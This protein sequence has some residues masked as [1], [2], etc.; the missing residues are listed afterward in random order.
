MDF[1]LAAV[2]IMTGLGV[3]FAA[4]LATADHFLRVEEDPKL[5][6]VESLLPG[7]NCGAC[8]EPGCR[9]LAG[10]LVEGTAEPAACTVSSHE[11]L[12]KIAAVL[13]V[14]VGVRE[15]VVARL[16]CAGGQGQVKNQAEYG[17]IFS[18]RAAV[19]INGGRRACS[20]GCLGL[21]DCERVCSFDAI[22]MTS[23]GLPSVEAELCTACGDC[24]EVCPLDL[25]VLVPVENHLFVQCNSPLAG[26]AAR[27][28]CRV[29]C[30]AC[31][32]CA[33]DAP[34]VIEMVN[35]LPVIDYDRD[36]IPPEKAT[37]RCPTGAI[38]WIEGNQFPGSDQKVEKEELSV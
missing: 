25:F 14:E 11:A 3:L 28:I 15:K 36:Q 1:I 12:E 19:L 4:I 9:A 32:R 17:G 7:T 29:A 23:D 33:A 38:V 22:T 21:A 31:G 13:G 24:V 35:G 30:D 37:W 6:E 2:L 20:W 18:C 16:K 10:K 8:G 5:D 34:E 26:D 27:A